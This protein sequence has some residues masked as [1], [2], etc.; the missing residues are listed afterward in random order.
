LSLPGVGDA[1]VIRQAGIRE[2]LPPSLKSPAVAC[3][4]P[5]EQEVIETKNKSKNKKKEE[6]K[7]KGKKKN[8]RTRTEN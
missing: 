3:P 2:Q 5:E 8:R 1:A 4:M 6:K 7:K